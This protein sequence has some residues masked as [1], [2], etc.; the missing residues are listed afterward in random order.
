MTELRS[1]LRCASI[2][3]G[4][5][6][7]GLV[8]CSGQV[9]SGA[10]PGQGE[11]DPGSALGSHPAALTSGSNC[12]RLLEHFQAELLRQ[13]EERAD[14]A[15][16][17]GNYPYPYPVPAAGQPV[18]DAAPAPMAP[19]GA[20]AGESPALAPG[21]SGTTVQVA[22]VDEADFVKADEDRIYLLHGQTLFVLDAESSGAAATRRSYEIALLE[23][24]DG[25]LSVHVNGRLVT[26]TVAG[27]RP[28]WARRGQEAGAGGKGPAR[29]TAPMP[30]KV[31]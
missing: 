7:L 13:M 5:Y 19:S 3:G 31:V 9:Q 6:T 25:G 21:F 17:G 8:G 20:G 1:L 22:G 24:P 29:V 28:A 27:A 12:D 16:R 30:G 23:Q 11:D 2:L 18:A 15:R 10:Q 14:Q 26:A 4:L